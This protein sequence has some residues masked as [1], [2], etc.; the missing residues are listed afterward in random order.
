MVMTHTDE[1]SKGQRS[2][3]SKIKVK[4]DGRTDGRRRLH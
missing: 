4:T 2:L 3:G 1:K